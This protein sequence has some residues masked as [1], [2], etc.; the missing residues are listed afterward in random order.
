MS[1]HKKPLLHVRARTEHTVE[2]DG[3]YV[4]VRLYR[5]DGNPWS[6]HFRVDPAGIGGSADEVLE[7]LELLGAELQKAV[8]LIREVVQA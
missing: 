6:A 3:T 5:I 7:R 4:H 8:R 1:E 2:A